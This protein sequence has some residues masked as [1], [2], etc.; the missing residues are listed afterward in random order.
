MDTDTSMD[1]RFIEETLNPVLTDEERRTF[2]VRDGVTFRDYEVF[3]GDHLFS[4]AAEELNK[5]RNNGNADLAF[6]YLR[7][8]LDK[9]RQTKPRECQ[10]CRRRDELYTRK[11][12]L[13]EVYYLLSSAV[14]MGKPKTPPRDLDD[15]KEGIREMTEYLHD[16]VR[17]KEKDN[18]LLDAPLE[19]LAIRGKFCTMLARAS[20]TKI[21][22]L[23]ERTAAE[24]GAVEGLGDA[25][26]SEIR[27]ALERHGFGFQEEKK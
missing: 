7:G 23:V 15:I 18:L 4:I 13:R 27:Y 1:I 17:I 2:A 19:K 26:M 8:Q 25:A 16:A 5:R 11:D 21:R 12:C 3:F 20:I 24:V 10:L 9:S 22:D 6:V 14:R